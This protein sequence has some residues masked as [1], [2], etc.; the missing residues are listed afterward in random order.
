MLGGV[1]SGDLHEQST[2]DAGLV[3]ACHVIAPHHGF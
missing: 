2:P 3:A 1:V